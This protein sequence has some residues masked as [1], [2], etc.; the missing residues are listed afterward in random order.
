MIRQ[1]GLT[2]PVRGCGR[3]DR[4]SPKL[5]GRVHTPLNLQT[6]TSTYSVR[7]APTHIPYRPTL[8]NRSVSTPAAQK[9]LAL[10]R[11]RPHAPALRE[12]GPRRGRRRGGRRRA[13]RAPGGVWPRAPAQTRRSILLLV[14]RFLLFSCLTSSRLAARPCAPAQRASARAPQA[15]PRAPPRPRRL[16][17][18]AL[19]AR[20]RPGLRRA[21]PAAP[22]PRARRPACA[23]ARCTLSALHAVVIAGLAPG[24]RPRSGALAHMPLARPGLHRGGLRRLR[25]WRLPAQELSV[26]CPQQ[27]T[28]HR[29]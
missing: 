6:A 27:C 20:R 1:A 23:H 8:Y 11:F 14:Q 19:R 9:T 2:R 15:R 17:R 22:R 12:R 28:R 10:P 21:G 3:H 4:G 25:V 16:R 7:R 26:T 5:A 18:R 13:P 24:G 29:G